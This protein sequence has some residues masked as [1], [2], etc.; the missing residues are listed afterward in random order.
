MTTTVDACNLAVARFRSLWG[1][2]TPI[3][4]E[5]DTGTPPAGVPW[6]RVSIRHTDA[7]QESLGEQ[8]QRRIVRSALLFVQ[9]FVPL[10]TGTTVA[11][12]LAQQA[13]Q[14]FELVRIDSNNVRFY[15][16]QIREL[17]NDGSFFG[18]LVEVPLQYDER[19]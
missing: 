4:L 7:E 16:P 1:T 15:V 17:G 18:I 9:V 2:T 3:F 12:T 6:V 5:N 8:G 13:R 14:I 19:V 11:R 10:N